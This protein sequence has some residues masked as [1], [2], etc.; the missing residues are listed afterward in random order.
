M[1]IRG[2]SSCSRPAVPALG[3]VSGLRRGR[4]RGAE[5]ADLTLA[6]PDTGSGDAQVGV[7][8]APLGQDLRV[9]VTRDGVR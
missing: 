4:P 3:L 9:V 5:L 2:S 1:L 6:K 7:A 8:G